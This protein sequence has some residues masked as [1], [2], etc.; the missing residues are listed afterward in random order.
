[1]TYISFSAFQ[2]YTRGDFKSPEIEGIIKIKADITANTNREITTQIH[3]S[4]IPL[5]YLSL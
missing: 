5:R 4:E 1:M 3:F 2:D